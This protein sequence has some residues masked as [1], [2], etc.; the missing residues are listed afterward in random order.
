MLGDN[1]PFIVH[2]CVQALA[3]IIVSA[4]MLETQ[5][6][7]DGLKLK[8]GEVARIASMSHDEIISVVPARLAEKVLK[9][10]IAIMRV[11]PG[12]AEGLPLNAEG[13]FAVNYSK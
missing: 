13:G 1:G 11:A 4:Q 5:D 8:A 2:N 3:R 6:Y 10:Q 9:K 7:F 12:W